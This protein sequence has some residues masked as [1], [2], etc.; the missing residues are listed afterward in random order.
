MS[1][2]LMHLKGN[3][4]KEKVERLSKNKALCGPLSKTVG[5][6]FSVLKLRMCDVLSM[7]LNFFY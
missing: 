3:D 5:N 4:V 1:R 2:W 7:R 6:M